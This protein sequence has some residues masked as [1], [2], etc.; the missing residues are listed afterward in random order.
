MRGSFGCEFLMLLGPGR[1]LALADDDGAFR[2][3]Q[4]FF[5]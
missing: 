1:K 3:R 5:Q 4:T 2:T